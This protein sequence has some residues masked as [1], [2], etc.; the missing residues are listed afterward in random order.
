MKVQ[1]KG[2]RKIQEKKKGLK[3]RERGKRKESISLGNLGLPSPSLKF[4][5]ETNQGWTVV[6]KSRDGS[7]HFHPSHLRQLHLMP[8][9]GQFIRKLKGE[10]NRAEDEKIQAQ[11]TECYKQVVF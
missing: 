11:Y 4:R 3:K 2:K 9:Q 1:E 5:Q 6:C 8:P 10:L 7:F